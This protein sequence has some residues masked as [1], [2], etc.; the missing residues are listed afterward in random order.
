MKIPNRMVIDGQ[1]WRI[2]LQ[3][4]LSKEAN[5]LGLCIFNDREIFIDADQSLREQRITLIHEVL[6]A[7][8]PRHLPRK[9]EEL[10]I[11]ELDGMLYDLIK[12]YFTKPVAKSKKS[13]GSKKRKKR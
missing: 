4:G 5:C 11:E 1:V 8:W 2:Y 3:K 12:R 9:T 7:I 13:K 10:L 6:H